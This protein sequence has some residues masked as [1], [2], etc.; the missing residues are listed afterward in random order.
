MVVLSLS[1][2]M[3]LA[4]AQVVQPDA[5]QLDA[6][7]FHDGLAAGEDGDIF[8]HGF[9]A[10]AEA[11]GLH[12]AGVQR[13]AQLVDHQGGER[14][15]F[16]FLGDDQQGLAGARD[17]LEHRQ[18]VLHVADLLLV[19]ENVGFLEHHFHALGVGD[20]VGGEVAA[21]ELHAVHGAQLGDH[22]LGFFHRDHAILADFLH[23][24]GDDVA[25]GRVAVGGNGADLGDHLARDRLRELLDF[26]NGHFDGL[27][28]AALERH[29][30]GARGDC[31]DAF[32]VNGLGQDGGGGGAVAGHIAGLGGHFADQLGAHVFERILQLDLFGHRDA[33]LGDVGAAEFLFEDHVA[34]LGA[35]GHFHCVGELINAT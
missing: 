8:Q 5:F 4:R 16:H 19:D 14:F 12:G 24:V 18:Q 34:A 2:V 35:E 11:G 21:V 9:A 29:G 15:A 20:E 33:V 10:V 17:L 7:L 28:D 6:G 25:D 27:L 31:L 3:R 13:A 30:V 32:A 1:T 26:G 22:G 23:G